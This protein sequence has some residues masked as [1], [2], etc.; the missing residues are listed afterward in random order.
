MPEQLIRIV[1]GRSK[2]ARRI[3]PM[4]PSVHAILKVRHEVQ[5]RPSDGWIL[6]VN[7]SDSHLTGDNAQ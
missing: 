1:D 3:L 6:P 2:A 7:S 4:T 5:G